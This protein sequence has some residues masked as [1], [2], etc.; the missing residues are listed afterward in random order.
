MAKST[1]R[2]QRLVPLT[3]H[4]QAAYKTSTCTR[5]CD[6]R[7]VAFAELDFVTGHSG[8]IG[9]HSNLVCVEHAVAFADKHGLD[10]TPQA[11]AATGSEG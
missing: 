2:N 6:Q 7:P 11:P 1:T 10:Y 8:R 5:N 4:Q 9:S 3:A